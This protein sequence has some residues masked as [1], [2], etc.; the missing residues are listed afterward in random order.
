MGKNTRDI[1]RV[2]LPNRTIDSE[3]NLPFEDTDLCR[4]STCPRSVVAE[5]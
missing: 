2:C 1:C 3:G 5:E 4:R